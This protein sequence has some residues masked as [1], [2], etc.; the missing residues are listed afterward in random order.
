M[1]R[2]EARTAGVQLQRCELTQEVHQQRPGTHL[3]PGDLR[4]GV[5]R[6]AQRQE[7]IEILHI[8][9]ENTSFHNDKRGGGM[10]PPPLPMKGR[11]VGVYGFLDGNRGSDGVVLCVKGIHESPEWFRAP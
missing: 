8:H 7:F 5:Q 4:A 11:N 2:V 6:G 1:R 3:L 9:M 10:T